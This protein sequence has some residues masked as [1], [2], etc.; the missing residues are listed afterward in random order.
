[1]W[2]NVLKRPHTIVGKRIQIAV[3]AN[4]LKM[5]LITQTVGKEKYNERA[6][7]KTI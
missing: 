6:T 3:V 5:K 4:S 2:R 1:M 7:A